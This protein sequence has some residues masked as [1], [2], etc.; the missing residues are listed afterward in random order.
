VLYGYRKDGSATGSLTRQNG[1]KDGSAGFIAAI[2]GDSHHALASIISWE[3][4]GNEGGLSEAY[5]MDLRNGDTAHIIN[6]PGRDMT[7][8]A[9]HQGRIR[10]VYGKDVNGNAKVYQ[11]PIDDDGWKEMPEMEQSRSYP[12]VFAADDR[13]AYFTCTPKSGGFGVCGWD[14]GTG[15]RTPLWSDPTVEADDVIFG[16]V[17]NQ[18]VG[19]EFEAGRQG[20]AMFDSTV[21]VMFPLA[22]A[23][24]S[25]IPCGSV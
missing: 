15:K 7:F 12:W 4:A 1:A 8:L 22:S 5:R 14:P 21:A 19:V 11:H 17:R 6:A 13:I 2:P 25:G 16:T 9:D 3:G 20:M 10:F 24:A 18:I 23:S